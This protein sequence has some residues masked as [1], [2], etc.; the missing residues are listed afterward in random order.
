MQ[1]DLLKVPDKP[2]MLMFGQQQTRKPENH[3]KNTPDPQ[4]TPED[5]VVPDN[6]FHSPRCF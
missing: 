6:I 2:V 1:S 5:A 4:N 3:R